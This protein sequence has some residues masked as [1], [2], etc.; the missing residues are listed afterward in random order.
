MRRAYVTSFA[1]T[2]LVGFGDESIQWILPGRFFEVKDVWLNAISGGLGLLV[3][4]FV[5]GPEG[6]NRDDRAE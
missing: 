1:L 4:R 5:S 3:L 6:G 2:V